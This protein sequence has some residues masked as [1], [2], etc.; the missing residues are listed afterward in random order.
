[1]HTRIVKWADAASVMYAL[2]II[3]DHSKTECLRA[4]R[5]LIKSPKVQQLQRGRY[6]VEEAGENDGH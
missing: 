1:M 3:K 2:G 4:H 6:L 5:L